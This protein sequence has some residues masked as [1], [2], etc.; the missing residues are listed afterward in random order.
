MG[1]EREL[2]LLLDGFERAKEG[3]GQ[4][5]SIVAEAG[6]GKSR[7]AHEFRK[8]V[9]NE[10]LAFLEGRCLSYGRGMAYRPV[11]EILKSIF[12]IQEGDEEEGIIRKAR[13]GLKALH[14]DEQTHLPYLL[15]LLSVKDSGIDKIL[16][17]PDARKN[18][19][20]EAFQW[21][22]LK[23]AQNRPLVILFEDLHW[24]DKSSEDTLRP[25]LEVVP[26]ARVLI[27]LTSVPI[28]FPL[29]GPSPTTAKSP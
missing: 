10:D 19:I 4:V 14:G 18:R 27:I 1:R 16:L 5:F 25:F 17:T 20:V 8:A 7:L 13:E 28:L 23:K 24:M 12:D 22:L 29:G 3:R 15:E 11:I 2:E 26:G 6:I 9:D 21:I